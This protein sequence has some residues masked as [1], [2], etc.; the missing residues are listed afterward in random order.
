MKKVC[1]NGIVT[2][3]LIGMTMSAPAAT[4]RVTGGTWYLGNKLSAA[5]FLL[6]SAAALS[7]N[8]EIRAP[9]TMAGTVSP[10]SSTA[11]IGTLSFSDAVVFNSGTFVCHAASD[12]SLDKISASGDVTGNATVQ[13]TRAAGASPLR[14]VVINGGSA[15]DYASFTVSPSTE[16]ALGEA[17]ALDL[18]VSL[19]QLPPAPQDVSASAGTYAF[20]VAV[21]WSAASGAAGYQV[22]R[23]TVDNSSSATLHGTTAL[24][25]YNDSASA[26]GITY[27]YW[28]KA[29]NSIGAGAFSSSASGW[30]ASTVNDYDGDGKSDLALFHD[31]NWFIYLMGSGGVITGPFGEP[32]WTP[33][34]GDYDGDG[35]SDLALFHDGKWLIY[36]MGRGDV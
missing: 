22:W 5:N 13:M 20:K 27:Y 15:S 9:A 11:D 7:G 17:G 25:G 35:K 1:R 34:P 31:G 6:G 26:V 36:L 30:R 2:V 23:N 21:A 14:Q 32:D 12:T 18:V 3:I 10:G 24:T 8:G 16:W 29:T 4:V 19:G 33:V 28:V